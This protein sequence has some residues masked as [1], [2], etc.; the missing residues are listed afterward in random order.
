MIS[1]LLAGTRIPL[2]ELGKLL[3]WVLP[4]RVVRHR[5]SGGGWG[6]NTVWYC[7]TLARTEAR[8]V[9]ASVPRSRAA[10]KTMIVA[11]KQA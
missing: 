11:Y 9:Q 6:L 3:V 4:F 2:V 8:R 1:Q 10:K 7:H 5:Q